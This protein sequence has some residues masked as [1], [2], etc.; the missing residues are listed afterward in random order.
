MKASQNA[1]LPEGS[2]SGPHTAESVAAIVSQ[3]IEPNSADEVLTVLRKCDG[4]LI[5]TRLLD[6]LPGGR[7]EWRLSRALGYTELR[8]RAYLSSGGIHR[9]GINLVLARGE[10]SEPLAANWV[11]RENPQ[12]FKNRR[13][14]NA[15]RMRALNDHDLLQR[16]AQLFNRLEELNRARAECRAQFLLL[17][18]HGEPLSPDQYV[19]E[20][21]CGLREDKQPQ[22]TTGV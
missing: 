6:K 4:Q 9:D 18:A 15:L 1:S 12:Y 13:E 11:E 5:T 19:L 14:R 21:V 8:N 20:R 22:E 16:V 17:V 7:V 2:S 3:H 10:T